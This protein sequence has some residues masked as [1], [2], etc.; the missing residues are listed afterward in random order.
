MAHYVDGFVVPVPKGKLDA[1]RHMAEECG[2]IWKEH[3]ALHKAFLTLGGLTILSS[4]SFWT[5]RANDGES[6]SRGRMP[7]QVEAGE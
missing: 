6:V 5:L 1:Y 2:K 4:L 7:T 3:G